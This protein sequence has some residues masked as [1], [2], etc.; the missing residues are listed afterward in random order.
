MEIPGYE[1]T[2]QIGKGGMASVY[3]A[4]QLSLS[5]PVVLKIMELAGNESDDAVR[6]G[7]FLEEGR[8]V[9]SLNH[10][11]IITVHDIG[12]TDSNSLYISMEYI[13]G[14]DL[15]SRMGIPFDPV[16]ALNYLMQIGSGL[17]VAH[18]HG[19]VHRDVKP[20]NILFREDNTPLLTDFGIAKQMDN[21][22]D[23]T[24]TSGF[25]GSPNYISPEQA[26]GNEID[27]RSDIYSLGCVFYEMLTGV[28]PYYGKNVYKVVTQH[29]KA[30]VPELPENL[31]RYQPFLDKIMAKDKEERFASAAEMMDGIKEILGKSEPSLLDLDLTG[32]YAEKKFKTHHIVLFLLLFVSVVFFGA[33][34]YVDYRLKSIP[35]VDLE[36]IPVATT[37]DSAGQSQLMPN[38]D[39]KVTEEMINALVWLGNKSLE[40]Y[41]LTYPE[42]DNAY[43]YFSRLLKI[44]PDNEIA[45]NGIKEIAERYAFLAEKSFANN[46]VDK[47]EAYISIGLKIDSQNSALRSL[48][49]LVDETREKS[50]LEKVKEMF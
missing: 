27:E 14:G 19:I 23:L 8:I 49:A 28:K 15:K 4:T 12:V 40:E 35:V 6:I 45:K 37:L 29:L 2:E 32:K 26:G 36:S 3:L 46:D 48:Q 5:R 22:L 21:D 30:P 44:R 13:K 11:N 41:K 10:P 20:A 7:R 25:L 43:Y 33:V 17:K 9:A 31:S 24:K 1:I 18:E 50:L 39:I 47:T 42:K 16:E 38:P 34:Q